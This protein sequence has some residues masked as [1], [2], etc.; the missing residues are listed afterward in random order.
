MEQS[1]FEFDLLHFVESQ[2]HLLPR[3]R[4]D[5]W[6]G[7]GQRVEHLGRAPRNGV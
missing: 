1:T 5:P 3:A 7:L 2:E 6:S 4:F